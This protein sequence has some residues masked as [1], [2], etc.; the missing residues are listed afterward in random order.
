MLC[1]GHCDNVSPPGFSSTDNDG[2]TA[3]GEGGARERQPDRS[4][5]EDSLLSAEGRMEATDKRR[6]KMKVCARVDLLYHNDGMW[7]QLSLAPRP[8]PPPVFVCTCSMQNVLHPIENWRQEWPG[9]EA[10]TNLG[11]GTR[12]KQN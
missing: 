4:K 5:D 1:G 11:L 7:C 8:F 2:S 9:D 10:S 6:P 12:Q 3:R